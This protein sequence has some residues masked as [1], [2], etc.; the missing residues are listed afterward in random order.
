MKAIILAGG[1]G[2]RLSEETVSRPKPM[3]EIGGMP[4]LWHIMKHYSHF[5]VN[6]FVVCCGYKGYVIKEYFANYFLHMSDVTFDMS[7]NTM[8]V[9][10][11]KAEPWK[12]T[13]VDTGEATMTG[14]RLKRV[15]EHVDDSSFFLTYGD[16]LSSVNIEELLRYHKN[17]GTV[18]TLTAV[19]PPGRFGSLSFERGRVLSFEEKPAGDGSWINGGFFVLEPEVFDIIEDDS[20]VWESEPLQRLATTG[21]L[22]AFHHSGFWQPM[23][24]LRDKQL[25]EDLWTNGTAPWKLWK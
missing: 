6:D 24:T 17:A 25:L 7:L 10:T 5:G 22:S 21:R 19:Q 16:G 15:R 13:L 12:V 23:D 2:T 3:V 20:T 11:R 18:A 8:Q 4:I 9:H 1:L 14:G